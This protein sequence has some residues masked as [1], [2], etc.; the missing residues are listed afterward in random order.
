M[1]LSAKKL[2]MMMCNESKRVPEEYT[3]RSRRGETNPK[4][5]IWKK[6]SR[7]GQQGRPRN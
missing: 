7:N 3:K 4:K 2:A 1:N 6:K 5:E